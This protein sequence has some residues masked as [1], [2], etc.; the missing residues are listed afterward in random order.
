MFTLIQNWNHVAKAFLRGV[1]LF[2]SAFNYALHHED[3]WVMQVQLHAFQPAFGFSI[4]R[5]YCV[6]RRTGDQE[7]HT[8]ELKGFEK[9]KYPLLLETEPRLSTTRQNAMPHHTW[10]FLPRWH[11]GTYRNE[12]ILISYYQF[13]QHGERTNLCLFQDTDTICG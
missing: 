6:T 4:H 12:Y 7:G 3:V 5:E 10:T 11:S 1:Q 13:Q 9:R 2:F 8:A